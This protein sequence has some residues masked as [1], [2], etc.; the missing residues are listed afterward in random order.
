MSPFTGWGFVLVVCVVAFSCFLMWCALYPD[1]KASKSNK[2]RY[3]VP[4]SKADYC[5]WSQ[6]NGDW[7]E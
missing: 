7:D 1:Y 3:E 5:D 4:T 6:D 2:V